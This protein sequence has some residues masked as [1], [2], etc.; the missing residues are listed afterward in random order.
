M[1]HVQSW[2]AAA[3]A[4]WL[5]AGLGGAAADEA[6]PPCGR[7]A[8]EI[9]AAARHGV[10]RVASVAID[11]YRLD[12][13]VRFSTGSGLVLAD[14]TVATNH[15]VV[16]DARQIAVYMGETPFPAEVLGMDPDL[17]LALLATDAA[18]SDAA[19]PFAPDAAAHRLEGLCA[20]VPARHRR[21]DELGNHFRP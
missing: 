2:R 19:L 16:A 1:K 9:H 11:P 6:A 12:Q 20:G 5:A 8:V 13:R 7:S 15:H 14:G 17:D 10:V 4:G 3:A 18:P 21:G